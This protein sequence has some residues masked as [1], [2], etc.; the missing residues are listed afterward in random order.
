MDK[1]LILLLDQESEE[2]AS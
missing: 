2:S 1:G